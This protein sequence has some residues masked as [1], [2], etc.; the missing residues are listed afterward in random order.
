MS[1]KKKYNLW[2]A[3]VCIGCLLLSY[4]LSQIPSVYLT[5]TRF[6]IPTLFF[7]VTTFGI[8][9]LL[10]RGDKDSKEFAFKTLAISMARLLVCLV[11]VLIYSRVS[12]SDS[13]AFACH[14]ML[15][16]LIFTVFEISSLLKYIK[17]AN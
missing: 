11:L 13:L 15:Q 2:F 14:F 8:N 3:L 16:Y 9:A 5:T 7:A 10:T 1:D 12:K 4:G 6:W 17:Q